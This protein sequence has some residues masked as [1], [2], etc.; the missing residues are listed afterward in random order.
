MARATCAGRSQMG[1]EHRD[2]DTETVRMCLFHCVLRGR[3]EIVCKLEGGH[4]VKGACL[5]RF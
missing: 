2:K 5:R 4:E 3:R 1:I